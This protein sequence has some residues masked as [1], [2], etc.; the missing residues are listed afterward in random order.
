M[1]VIIEGKITEEEKQMLFDLLQ[2]YHAANHPD[3]SYI[4]SMNII[5]N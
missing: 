5:L 1:D 3:S 2:Q 4:I